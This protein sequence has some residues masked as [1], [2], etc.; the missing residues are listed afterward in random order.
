[1]IATGGWP[2][3]PEFPGSELALT[4]NEIFDLPE[5]PQR[6]VVVGGGYIAVEFAGIFSGL[7]SRVTQLYRG[8]LFL[9]GFDDEVRQHLADEMVKKGI[10][11]R[12]NNN[13]TR[14]DKSET[15]YSAT[16]TD[17]STL[18]TDLI[19]YATGRHPNTDN[20]GL[21]QAGVTLDE[22]G[23]IEVND[24]YQTSIPSILL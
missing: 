5:F 23:A 24:D 15:G 20:L 1:M 16:L 19:M 10:D 12:F 8:P 9:R 11:L 22:K 18:E 6:V 17:G 7:G 3:V 4:S 21:E 2:H 13:I 14:I